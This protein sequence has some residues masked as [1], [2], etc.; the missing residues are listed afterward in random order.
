[1]MDVRLVSR[2]S[3]RAVV[4][5]STSGAATRSSY[6]PHRSSRA[7]APPKS[8]RVVDEPQPQSLPLVIGSSRQTR[9][10]V[11]P[12]APRTSKRPVA[13]TEVSGTKTTLS[14]MART[15]RPAAP[16]NSACQSACWATRD[17]AGSARPPP[18][19]MDELISAMAEPRRSLGSSSRMMPMPS[20][21]APMAKP[22][23]ALPTSIVVMSTVKPQISEPRTMNARLVSNIRR[24]PYRSPRRPMMG[25]ATAPVSS[26]AVIT[27]VALL[28]AVARRV[29]RSLMT[30]TSIVCMTAT[31]MPAKA[32]TGTTAPLPVRRA[33]SGASRA[34]AVGSGRGC[35]AVGAGSPARCSVV[36]GIGAASGRDKWMP[37]ERFCRGGH[38]NTR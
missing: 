10:P 36:C 23:S 9:P 27:Q 15:P 20:G 6:R 33:P 26:V 1:M 19:P 7:T 29:G 31:T 21:M 16:K 24:L 32:R 38:S 4:R 12:M 35:A 11:S 14:S 5:R 25:V 2:T 17:A 8:P 30:G 22:C 18:T 34:A 3:R 37:L 28:G 13:R